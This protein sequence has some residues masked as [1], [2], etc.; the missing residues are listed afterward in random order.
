MSEIIFFEGSES[1]KY[2]RSTV[3]SYAAGI[4]LTIILVI[5]ALIFGAMLSVAYLRWKSTKY[6]VTSEKIQIEKGIISKKINNLELWRINDIQYKQG[7]VQRIFSEATLVL[8]TQDVS[9]PILTFSG[10]GAKMT[11]E[12]FDKLQPAI[13]QAR[14]EHKVVSFS[15]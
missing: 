8:V 3:F 11:R 9:S 5:P 2:H 4:L 10:L 7:I 14:K 6:K 12:L 1:P 13:A 15:A